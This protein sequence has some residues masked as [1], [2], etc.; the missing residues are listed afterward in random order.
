MEISIPYLVPP[1]LNGNDSFS[2]PV[3]FTPSIAELQ[4]ATIFRPQNSYCVHLD[5]D[6]DRTFL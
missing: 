6:T 5:T 1:C 3:V 2:P 4:L